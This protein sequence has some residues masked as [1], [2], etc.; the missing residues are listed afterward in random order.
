ML[1]GI[2]SEKSIV[3]NLCIALLMAFVYLPIGI[4]LDRSDADPEL[5]K[6][7]AI[8]HRKLTQYVKVNNL[9][10]IEELATNQINSMSA[11]IDKDGYNSTYIYALRHR[12]NALF[13][14]KK[15]S[16][17][18]HDYNEI[19]RLKDKIM[20]ESARCSY[21]LKKYRSCIDEYNLCEEEKP[22]LSEDYY[23]RGSA[24]MKLKKY[25]KALED[26]QL[27]ANNPGTKRAQAYKKIAYCYEKLGK[28][29]QALEYYKKAE[30]YNRENEALKKRIR[31]LGG[32]TIEDEQEAR[33]LEYE[34]RLQ[35]GKQ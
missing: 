1:R 8:N 6:E 13:Q 31:A 35:Q 28:K 4:C 33:R 7:W 24:Y 5:A 11:Y 22:L 17:A 21:F 12:A 27:S 29:S 3:A 2:N 19:R 34:Q 14:K 32:M 10:K 18:S 23:Y 15:Y 26:L 20:P 16:L 25:K 30:P 9:K